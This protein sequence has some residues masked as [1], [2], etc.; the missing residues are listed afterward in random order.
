[1]SQE[2]CDNLKKRIYEQ[3]KKLGGQ[4]T[5]REV[6]KKAEGV[7][8]RCDAKEGEARRKGR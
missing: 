3:N 7:A 6:E 2:A 8:Q 1:M 4:M 5:G